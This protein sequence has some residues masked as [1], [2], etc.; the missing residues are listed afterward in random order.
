MSRGTRVKNPNPWRLINRQPPQGVSQLSSSQYILLFTQYFMLSLTWASDCN[1]KWS[2]PLV[3]R[4][5]TTTSWKRSWTTTAW[6]RSWTITAWKGSVSASSSCR[7]NTRSKS[8]KSS[9]ILWLTSSRRE[10]Y[11]ILLLIRVFSKF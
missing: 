3:P 9:S 10:Q 2:P 1:C 8:E 11:T 4:S 7:P 6:K 5:W